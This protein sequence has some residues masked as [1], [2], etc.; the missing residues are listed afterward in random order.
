[1]DVQQHLQHLPAAPVLP[2]LA[3]ETKNA[4]GH[5]QMFPEE[6]NQSKFK[7]TAP[8]KGKQLSLMVLGTLKFMK[9]KKTSICNTLGSYMKETG[10]DDWSEEF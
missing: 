5:P 10:G 4:C 9:Q 7:I 1:M 8:E 3:M 6:Q 2:P